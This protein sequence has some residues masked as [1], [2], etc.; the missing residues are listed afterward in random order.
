MGI[1][2]ILVKVVKI[3]L[4]LKEISGYANALSSGR[5]IE[6]F[7]R[8]Q[9]SSLIFDWL[10]DQGIPLKSLDLRKVAADWVRSQETID[11][12]E[13][14][15][16]PNS[17]GELVETRA[18]ALE[19][20]RY[21]HS[22]SPPIHNQLEGA[23]PVRFMSGE[24]REEVEDVVMNGAG[25]RF[26]FVRTH[27]SQ[28]RYSGPLGPGWDH[29]ANL[30][31]REEGSL[32]V[33]RSTG[34][35]R[36][37]L[38]VLHPRD[39]QA[40]HC[41]FS[42]ESGDD[43]VLVRD[44]NSFILLSPRGER[45]RYQAETQPGYHRAVEILDRYG[46]YIRFR[47][48]GDHLD[49]LEI[50]NPQRFLALEYDATY[51]L[52]GLVD[53]TGRRWQY[54]YDSQGLLAGV[55]TPATPDQRKGSITRYEYSSLFAPER[56]PIIRVWDGEGRLRTENE[57]EF[58]RSSPDFLCVVR[59]IERGGEHSFVYE[60]LPKRHD[61]SLDELRSVPDRLV[62][63]YS[64]N[65]HERKL[66]F[67]HYGQLLLEQDRIVDRGR[68]RYR[69]RLFRYNGDGRIIASITP[70]GVITQHHYRR[71]EFYRDN[72]GPG[73]PVPLDDPLD[74]ATRL[75]FGLELSR[76]VRARLFDWA[77]NAPS[78]L[79]GDD[80]LPDPLTALEDD[81]VIKWTYDRDI[82]EEASRSDSEHTVS[83]D[84]RHVESIPLGEL[85]HQPGHPQYIA[86]QK[87]L[88]RREYS[89]D[90]SRSLMQI[91]YPDIVYP[92]PVAG[93][94]GYTD[95]VE[96]FVA[97]DAHGRLL[98]RRDLSGNRW[99][100]NYFDATHGSLEGFLREEIKP[101]TDLVID[102]LLPNRVD[103]QT[104]G[105]WTKD[106]SGWISKPGS[107]ATLSFEF[108]GG[109]VE[110]FV[111]A[112]DKAALGPHSNVQVEIDGL[113]LPVWNQTTEASRFRGGL[114][115]GKHRLE[116]KSGDGKA[117]RIGR[118]RTYVIVS[119]E[120]D[121]LGRANVIYD[122]RSIPTYR[123]LD[124]RDR[125]VR[126]TTSIGAS[127]VDHYDAEGN[128]VRR[129]LD[130]IDERGIAEP[131]GPEVTQY[132][133]DSRGN[134]VGHSTGV[135]SEQRSTRHLYNVDGLEIIRILP[136]GNRIHFGYDEVMRRVW[137]ARG[138]CS[139][140]ISL[141]RRYFD[142]GDNEVIS[143]DPLG[144][145]II[146]ARVNPGGGWSE[147]L[148]ALRRTQ[149]IFFPDGGL[150][151]YS[152][153]KRGNIL[154]DRKFERHTDGSWIL[155]SHIS[156][157]YAA[158]DQPI[159]EVQARFKEPI[160]V[161]DPFTNPDQEF[162]QRKHLGLV[163]DLVIRYAYD[164]SGRCIYT[165]APDG[166]L[167]WQVFDPQGN[168]AMKALP[169]GSVKVNYY[170]AAC[171]LV[172]VDE[173]LRLA[174]PDGTGSHVVE[175]ISKC[176]EYDSVN[177]KIGEIDGMGNRWRWLFDS[178]DY[179]RRQI[180]PLGNVIIKDIDA[181]GQLIAERLITMDT[182]T[183]TGTSSQEIIT[184]YRYD[185]NGNLIE[186]INPRSQSIYLSYDAQDR[187]RAEERR[188]AA[189]IQRMLL[190]YDPAGNI[191]QRTRPSGLVEKMTYNAGNK[192]IR[193][194]IDTSGITSATDALGVNAV[195][196][197]E[198]RYDTLGRRI[199]HENDHCIVNVQYDSIGHPI[200]EIIT[201]QGPVMPAIGPF[202]IE[203]SHDHAGRL[204]Q[205]QYPSGRRMRYHRIAGGTLI[206]VDQM[207][208]G[209]NYP[210]DPAIP[211][212]FLLAE[213]E[214]GGERIRSASLGNGWT[215]NLAI[216][217]AGK[218][219]RHSAQHDGN[220]VRFG[221][222]QLHDGAGNVR[223]Q[224]ETLQ[225]SGVVG[226]DYKLNRR[227]SYDSLYRLTY[228]TDSA[229]EMVIDPKVIAPSSSPAQLADWNGQAF[230]DTKLGPLTA[231]PVPRTYE[232]DNNGNRIVSREFGLP[233]S[234]YSS[235]VMDRYTDI[236]GIIRVHQSGGSLRS[237]G[238]NLYG[239]DH[240]DRMT[241][242]FDEGTGAPLVGRVLDALG[243]PILEQRPGS[244][245]V[246][247]WE[248]GRL[249]EA[250]QGGKIVSQ[251]VYAEEGGI[252]LHTAS[253]SSDLWYLKDLRGSARLVLNSVGAPISGLCYLPFGAA[254]VSLG[255][256]MDGDFGFT[257][258][259]HESTP[260]VLWFPV[261]TY[262]PSN[263]RF[264]QMDPAGRLDGVNSYT[265]AHNNPAT[266]IDPTGMLAFVDD[267]LFWGIGRLIGLRS[268]GFFAG[269][270]QNFK[271][272]WSLIAGTFHTFHGVKNFGDFMAGLG[273]LAHKLTWGLPNELMG[274]TAGYFAV[275]L[276]G[277]T[278]K[279]WQH[280][281]LIEV[282]SSSFGAFTL[283]S[284]VVGDQSTLS[285]QKRHEQGHYFQ[286]LLLGPF[287]L[288]VI[289]IPS[290]VHAGIYLAHGQ[291][292]GWN[293]HNFYTESWAEAWK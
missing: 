147:G 25:V 47:Y 166:A 179:I 119:Y 13:V 37:V 101:H 45:I 233:V 108:E 109:A 281:Q 118:L 40:G 184:R 114:A 97:R 56:Y 196:F 9:I 51:H 126:I 3:L 155:L 144:Q 30:W 207:L 170:D 150:H 286:N 279:M 128:L 218:P 284:K 68:I 131:G 143:V 222:I 67:N 238:K 22:S 122:E 183:G 100:L 57:Y 192:L 141:S 264:L 96:S 82:Q 289:A 190:A 11:D 236:N 280:V 78:V 26:A 23:D 290:L 58:S 198:F 187:L 194:D 60:D 48:Q 164:R 41:Y 244:N 43:S 171:N 266:F 160:V 1:W 199:K 99:F 274:I 94:T 137:A 20:G 135:S 180:D 173:H 232:Y 28:A 133:Y 142:L 254:N 124:A 154:I 153:D 21:I 34:D 234:T 88:T 53:H 85:G 16:D 185:A 93:I 291:Y 269:T 292:R 285:A 250:Y 129:E 204:L 165:L 169:Q 152:F 211:D 50:N 145:A 248:S 262:D 247:V 167:T 115:P 105:V 120:C 253:N 195:T 19:D 77:T 66:W 217:A 174:H 229:P 246:L 210:G 35:L 200:T 59:Q 212:S 8:S 140:E 39:G 240:A 74:Q 245:T 203:R 172:R 86:H 17:T 239:Y 161:S 32:V 288:P 90:P 159:V 149:L 70:E 49:R 268:D 293:Y 111:D 182:G 259:R 151:N 65:G 81:V 265:Y 72:P 278:T 52:K 138:A 127:T 62:H 272:S 7:I 123:E 107:L 117:F 213:F 243:Q 202:C 276:F 197:E 64:R 221:V 186:V 121:A 10:E 91:R 27:R 176:F 80:P 132:E 201:F 44:G 75:G 258:H 95:L 162:I 116:F 225:G 227:L 102:H 146:K 112:L 181:F 83:P 175:V 73:G 46:N 2:A 226:V 209:P 125:V 256:L 219:I 55:V 216:N 275:E 76:V 273:K 215:W 228:Y 205:L 33:A 136:R 98:E 252:P 14:Q 139:D 79:A 271:E 71:D 208:R 189:S 249:I 177:R 193:T 106:T 110:W 29:S 113:A 282:P 168:V 220:G 134:L 242:I 130:R 257:G 224:Q 12:F 6:A 178:R 18:Q 89:S 84:P 255:T 103:L 260:G 230:I 36:E 54:C 38:H 163:E 5:P 237:D 287:Y 206:K 270:W 235:D 223:V 251:H 214:W 191:I 104:T 31:L 241:E 63:V 158:F 92:A 188:F 263:G 87:G 157:V 148:D 4:K 61:V 69:H 277:A 24:F 156:Y 15:V 283:G 231:G 267:A 42:A 261:R